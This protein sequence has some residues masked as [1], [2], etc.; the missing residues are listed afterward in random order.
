MLSTI[1]TVVFPAPGLAMLPLIFL[2]SALAA[3]PETVAL[4]WAL[5]LGDQDIGERTASV[6]VLP[7]ERGLRRIVEVSTDVEAS[8][9]GIPITYQQRLTAHA[10]TG[11][12]SF[13]SVVREQGKAREIQGRSN[14]NGWIVTV[15]ES[16]DTRTWDLPAGKI[17][18][19]TADLLDPLT[20]VALDRFEEVRLLSAETGD[21]FTVSVEPLGSSTVDLGG[22]KVPVSGYALNGGPG[23]TKLF[24][25]A[26]GYLVRHETRILGKAVTATL[27]EAPPVSAD[28]APLVQADTISET[29]I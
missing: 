2:S 23:T 6:K 13:H 11:P 26:S 20:Q 25:S 29:D 7:S 27:T 21:V 24:Y 12:A 17:D 28:D 22:A 1:A 3:G 8:V 18:L 14:F 10:G 19:S 4:T 5:S 16:S 15:V 9:M